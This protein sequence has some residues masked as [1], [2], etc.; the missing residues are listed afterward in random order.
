[1]PIFRRTRLCITA[2][3][4]LH[5]NTVT[6]QNTIRSYTQ[7]CSTE[8]GLNIARNMLIYKFDNKHQ[9][10]CIFLVSLSSSYVHDLRSQEP[11]IFVGLVKFEY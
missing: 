11:K 7:S 5:C 6:M 2:N 9:I 3:G 8:D 10:S 1:M 4:V